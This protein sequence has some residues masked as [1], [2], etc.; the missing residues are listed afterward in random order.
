MT[1]VTIDNHYWHTF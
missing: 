1:V